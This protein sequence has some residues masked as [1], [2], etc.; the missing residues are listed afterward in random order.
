MR[1]HFY[2]VA[3]HHSAFIAQGYQKKAASPQKNSRG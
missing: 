3:Y 2:L 1:A